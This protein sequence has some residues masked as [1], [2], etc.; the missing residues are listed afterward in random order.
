MY[1]VH[2]LFAEKLTRKRL[3][4]ITFKMFFVSLLFHLIYL[5]FMC[6]NYGAYANDGIERYGLK[7]FGKS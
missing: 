5:F 4:H 3:L 6:V 7:T 1:L 2:P